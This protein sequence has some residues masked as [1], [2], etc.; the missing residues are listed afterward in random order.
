MII[1]ALHLYAI[2]C[3]IANVGYTVESLS[4]RTRCS[5]RGYKKEEDINVNKGFSGKYLPP[6]A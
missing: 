6:D 5:N 4:S 1:Y 3:G 2:E